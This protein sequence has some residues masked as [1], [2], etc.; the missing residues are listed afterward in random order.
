MLVKE[1][2]IVKEE[3]SETSP[4]AVNRTDDDIIEP[5]QSIIRSNVRTPKLTLMG[6][7]FL[8]LWVTASEAGYAAMLLS[9]SNSGA[10]A[11]AKSIAALSNNKLSTNNLDIIINSINLST[12]LCNSILTPLSILDVNK[13]IE[14]AKINWK[15]GIKKCL[16]TST[17]KV[18]FCTNLSFFSFASISAALPI[19][20]AIIELLGEE[21]YAYFL[22]SLAFVGQAISFWLVGS[23]FIFDAPE[24]IRRIPE[25]YIETLRNIL[26]RDRKSITFDLRSFVAN[27]T[28]FMKTYGMGAYTLKFLLPSM[29]SELMIPY[30]LAVSTVHAHNCLFTQTVVDYN[31][32]FVSN[33]VPKEDEK[34]DIDLSGKRIMYFFKLF[35]AFFL[36]A[37]FTNKVLS[38]TGFVTNLITGDEEEYSILD[39]MACFAVFIFQMFGAYQ[40]VIFVKTGF[41]DPLSITLAQKISKFF[42]IFT[43]KE[44]LITG[45]EEINQDR[46]QS[47]QA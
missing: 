13:R 29:Y 8:W 1:N 21:E 34:I 38:S 17:Q 6:Y 5:D 15:N 46:M 44:I 11:I 4:L 24:K 20:A 43:K 40:Q 32:T 16:S 45:E 9:T 23:S 47:M 28:R 3:L 25:T 12:S 30:S 7:S 19:S 22:A 42:T 37:M 10:N 33:A 2:E 39:S 14:D 26:P 18:I 41:T 31:E 27:T 36:F 35:F